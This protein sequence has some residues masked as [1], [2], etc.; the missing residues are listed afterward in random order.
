MSA[1]A[2]FLQRRKPLASEVAL[3]LFE[4]VLAMAAGL[5]GYVYF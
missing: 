2:V 1:A 4:V 3:R 5:K